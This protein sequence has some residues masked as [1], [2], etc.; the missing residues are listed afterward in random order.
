PFGFAGV[1]GEGGA[2]G[3]EF[4][5]EVIEVVEDQGF[6]DHGGLG[7]AEFV[8][9]V[10]ADEQVLDDGLQVGGETLDGVHS[11]RNGFEF[12]HDVAEK[13][14]FDGVG[15]GALIAQFV[16]LPDIVKNRGGQQQI[17]VEFGIVRGGLFGEATQ[18][19]DV[20][21]KAA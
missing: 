12:H 13:L 6:A 18:A 5:I 10:M 4:G 11:F 20:F 9:A 3:G 16:E 21:Y 15:N 14:A 17:H 7:G 8:L 2:G 1:N 19:Q